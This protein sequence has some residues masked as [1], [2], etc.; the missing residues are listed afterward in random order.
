MLIENLTLRQQLKKCVVKLLQG[1]TGNGGFVLFCFACSSVQ[2]PGRTSLVSAHVPINNCLL[3]S[4]LLCDLCP[5]ILLAF[6]AKWFG[7]LSISLK[8]WG[9]GYKAQILCSSRRSWEL[10]SLPVV[11]HCAGHGVYSKSVSQ[12]F[13]SISIWIF[14]VT[15]GIGVIQLVSRFLSEEI[16][17]CVVVYLVHLWQEKN[18]R[19]S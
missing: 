18:S 4:I 17:L 7:H 1:K 3:F 14:S 12:P 15:E 6:R 13:L 10:E 9:T 8:S 2:N 5:Q 16:S 19:V 11:R